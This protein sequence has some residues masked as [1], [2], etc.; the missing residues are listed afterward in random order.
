MRVH[1]SINII[2][3]RIRKHKKTYR[4]SFDS[5]NKGFFVNVNK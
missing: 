1:G 4:N 3:R 2:A 5:G